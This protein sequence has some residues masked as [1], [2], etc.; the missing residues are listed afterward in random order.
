ML[1]PNITLDQFSEEAVEGT[2]N[3]LINEQFPGTE[4]KTFEEVHAV[5]QSVHN[6]TV[7][8]VRAGKMRAADAAAY[9]FR[10]YMEELA[11]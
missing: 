7:Q 10:R 11:K 4:G 3:D 5:V 6:E 1:N 8:L 9:E 2:T